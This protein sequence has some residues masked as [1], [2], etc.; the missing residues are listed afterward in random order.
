MKQLEYKL[1]MKQRKFL[2]KVKYGKPFNKYPFSISSIL[3]TGVYSEVQR[4]RINELIIKWMN[5]KHNKQ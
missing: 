2:E 3:D 1:T 4:K 5:T